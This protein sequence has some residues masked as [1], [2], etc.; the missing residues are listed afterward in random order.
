MKASKWIWYPLI[1]KTLG[2]SRALVV[3]SPTPEENKDVVVPSKTTQEFVYPRWVRLLLLVVSD[4]FR[5]CRT[6]KFCNWFS[7][8]VSVLQLICMSFKWLMDDGKL[9]SKYILVE[10][11]SCNWFIFDGSSY[12]L[13][14]WVMHLIFICRTTKAC[15]FFFCGYMNRYCYLWESDVCSLHIQSALSWYQIVV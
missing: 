5:R 2:T 4:V 3:E 7:C 6:Y 10:L 12:T 15:S 14:N 11:V 9:C 1:S 8:P 13:Y